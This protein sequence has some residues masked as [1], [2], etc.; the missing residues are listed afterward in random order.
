M[1]LRSRVVHRLLC[2]G[3]PLFLCAGALPAQSDPDEPPDF[4]RRVD[5]SI[6]TTPD[7]LTVGD[8][9]TLEVRVAAPAGYEVTLSPG[10]PPGVKKADVKG[11]QLEEPQPVTEAQA[12]A[13]ATWVGRYTLSVFDVGEVTLPPWPVQV[14]ADTQV[15]VVHTDSIHLFVRS[16]LDDSLQA[17]DLRDIKPQRQIG[18]PLP[19]WVLPAVLAFLLL[20]AAIWWARRRRQPAEPAVPLAPPRP[21]HE[22][23]LAELRKL[24]SLR[25]PYDGRIKEHYVRLSEILRT[26]LEDARAFQV[27]ALEETTYEIVREL[28]EKQYTRGV[29]DEVAAMC[30][31]ADLVKFAKHQPTV[32]ECIE[33]LERLRRFLL[34]TSRTSAHLTL[35]EVRPEPVGVAVAAGAAPEPVGPSA[36]E[37]PPPGAAEPGGRSR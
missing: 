29:V 22:V 11:F 21:A 34:Q 12:D 15:A 8:P 26:Y 24:E 35:R 14:R 13:Y 17:A 19:A 1:P 27:A 18:V 33:A 7:S 6:H 32:E 2:W 3:A 30:G 16:V 4:L 5:I 36:P 25:L 37:P 20:L 23:A 28:E 10:A 9:L 31:E